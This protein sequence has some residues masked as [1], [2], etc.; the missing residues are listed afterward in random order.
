MSLSWWPPL[1]LNTH[2]SHTNPISH[3]LSCLLKVTQKPHFTNN[4]P[5]LHSMTTDSITD[6]HNTRLTALALHNSTLRHTLHTHP[7]GKTLLIVVLIEPWLWDLWVKTTRTSAVINDYGLKTVKRNVKHREN[8]KINTTIHSKKTKFCADSVGVF[9]FCSIWKKRFGEWW[10]M[11]QS[12]QKTTVEI[13]HMSYFYMVN[14]CLRDKSN[15]NISQ[16]VSIL[17]L[18]MKPN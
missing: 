17:M 6:L 4:I 14:I 10:L 9:I 8:R 11:F 12:S 15:V 16:K 18:E 5:P 1:T 2:A 7:N 13:Q 3:T